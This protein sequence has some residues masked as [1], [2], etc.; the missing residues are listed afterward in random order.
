[1]AAP[2]KTFDMDAVSTAAVTQIKD[3]AQGDSRITVEGVVAAMIAAGSEIAPTRLAVLL[4][5]LSDSNRLGGFYLRRGLGLVHEDAVPRPKKKRAKKAKAKKAAA[6]TPSTLAAEIDKQE[7][8]AAM[9]E[10]R[11]Q[12]RDKH[13]KAL[14]L[15]S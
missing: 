6:V 13:R 8:E 12:C 10:F 11:A 9:E 3:L 1:M 15:A 14:G 4:K 2:K 7:Q 5:E